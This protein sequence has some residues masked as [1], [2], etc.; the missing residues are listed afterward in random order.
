M[1]NAI[2]LK[3]SIIY[4]ISTVSFALNNLLLLYLSS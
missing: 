1:K 2:R 3:N 4:I